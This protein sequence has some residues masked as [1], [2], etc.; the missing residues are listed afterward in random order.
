MD[1]WRPPS[2]TATELEDA[3]AGYQRALSSMSNEQLLSQLT[4]INAELERQA[5]T[6]LTSVLLSDY[7]RTLDQPVLH[8]PT[9][10]TP[11]QPADRATPPSPFRPPSP[12]ELLAASP[13]TG[14]RLAARLLAASARAYR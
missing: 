12:A 7:Q 8:S 2:L 13:R 3:L 6:S 11:S 14:P 4:A 10:A 5:R 9:P 1:S